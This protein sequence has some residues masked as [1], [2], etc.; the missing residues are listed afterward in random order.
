MNILSKA[1]QIIIRGYQL[2][3]SPYLAQ[4]CRFEPSCSRYAYAA[5]DEYGLFQGLWLAMKRVIR[6]H[7]WSLGGHDPLTQKEKK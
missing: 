1:G 6:C 7:P 4:S 5:L 3:I 2:C